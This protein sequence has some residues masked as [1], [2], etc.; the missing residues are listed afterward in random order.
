MLANIRSRPEK[1]EFLTRS[2]IVNDIIG[3]KVD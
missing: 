2:S 3:L 1:K